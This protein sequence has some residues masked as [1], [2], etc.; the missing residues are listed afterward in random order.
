[1]QGSARPRWGGGV[2]W[3]E[4][5]EDAKAWS[6]Q[7]WDTQELG[8]APCGGSAGLKGGEGGDSVGAGG[9][10]SG[11]F[12]GPKLLGLGC[13]TTLKLSQRKP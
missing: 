11:K 2:L 4:G 6:E 13:L 7:G 8:A 9:S 1:M 10:D 5:I 12:P 3:S